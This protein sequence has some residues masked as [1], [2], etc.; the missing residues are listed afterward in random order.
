MKRTIE[1][2]TTWTTKRPREA[3]HA[4]LILIALWLGSS[5]AFI[6]K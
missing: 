2:L 3:A 4:L 6:L 5:L 1:R